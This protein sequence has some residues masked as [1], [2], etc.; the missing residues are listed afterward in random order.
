MT[1]TIALRESM[2]NGL[3]IGYHSETE[4]TVQTG[5]YAKGSY[6]TRYTI[7]GDMSKAV[8]YYNCINIG[9]GY[10]KRLVMAG[11]VIAKNKS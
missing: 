1:K 6:T 5:R 4:F 7:S 8:F 3:K 11:K 9:N 2:L 10:K